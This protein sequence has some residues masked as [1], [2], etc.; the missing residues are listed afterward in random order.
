MK[1][2]VLG[3]ALIAMSVVGFNAA[4]QDNG[5]CTGSKCDKNECVK[6]AKGDKAKKKGMKEDRN[7]FAGLTLTEAQKTK[8]QQLDEKNRSEMKAKAEARRSE[9]K[10]KAEARRAEKMRNDSVMRSE[11]RASQKAYLEEVKA[12]LGPD[13]YVAFLENFYLNAG[14]A[15]AKGKMDM[16]GAPG[17][18][19][20]MRPGKGNGPKDGKRAP[21][22]PGKPEVK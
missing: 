5:K 10:G 8:L 21:E 4:A 16:K 2:K 9:M 6:N 18:K 7:P 22:K 12:I 19:E 20:G 3:F 13:Q 1:K 15:P 11:R 17:R 14:K